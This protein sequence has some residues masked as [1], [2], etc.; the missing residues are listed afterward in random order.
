MKRLFS[1]IHFV[2]GQDILIPLEWCYDET[3]DWYE[4]G[5]TFK[6]NSQKIDKVEAI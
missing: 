3:C 5:H 4:L 2:S 1:S 6:R